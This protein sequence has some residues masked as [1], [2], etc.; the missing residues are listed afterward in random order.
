ME[1]DDEEEDTVADVISEGQ[2]VPQMKA[3]GRRTQVMAPKV[4]IPQGWTPPCFAKTADEEQFLVGVMG[5][6]KLL[7]TLTPSDRHTLMAALDKQDF[8]AGAV[9]IKQGDAG[10][11]FYIVIDGECDIS[12]EGKGSVMK[13]KKGLTFGELALLHNAPR[14]ATVTALTPVKT[15]TLDMLS[16]KGILMTKMESDQTAYLG[17]LD[18]VPG[19]ADLSKGEKQKMA[20]ALKEHVYEAGMP[21]ITEGDVGNEMFIIRDGEVK[22]TKNGSAAEVSRRLTRGDFFGEL[23]LKSSEKRAATVTTTVKTTVLSMHRSAY[24]RITTSLEEL[25][26]RQSLGQQRS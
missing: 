22:C 17:F 16:F 23:A 10:D 15:F 7:K 26:A 2:Q 6:N 9:I 5:E 20:S 13:A 4:D 24:E 25:L 3:R 8:A 19:I 11:K 18:A 21:I 1:Y 14:A 12:V